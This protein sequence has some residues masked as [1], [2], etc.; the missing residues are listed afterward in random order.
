MRP[1]AQLCLGCG[2]FRRAAITMT[3]PAPTPGGHK[4][5]LGGDRLDPAG[6]V[7][8]MLA[9]VVDSVL[10]VALILGIA[11]TIA[12][13][14]RDF[15]AG[16][17]VHVL[18][19][20]W[21]LFLALQVSYWAVFESTYLQATPGKLIFSIKVADE[22]G[23]RLAL[24]HTITRAIAKS[25]MIDFVPFTI[26]VAFLNEKRQTLYDLFVGTRVIES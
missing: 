15:S 11:G 26:F 4:L 13:G 6:L 20:L 22:D 7:V 18:A 9:N 10:L 21:W 25:L 19:S 23:E 8:R 17:V 2:W 3:M 12:F 24:V 14:Q 5:Y 16:G 1:E